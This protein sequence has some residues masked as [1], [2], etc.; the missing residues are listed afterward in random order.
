[1][2]RL[3]MS[4][5]KGEALPPGPLAGKVVLVAGAS[6]G[7]G[8]A[9]A[10]ASAEAGADVATT[11]R[12]NLAGAEAMAADVRATGRRAVVVPADI[13]REEDLARLAGILRAEFDRVDAW[14]NNAGADILTGAGAR[15]PRLEKL[16]LLLAVDLRGTMLASWAAADVMRTQPNGGTIINMSWDG[17]VHGLQGENPELFSAVKGG[18][19]SFSKSLARSVAPKIRVNVLCPGWIETAFGTGAHQDFKREVA[20]AIPLGRWGTPEDVAGAAVFLASDASSYLTGQMI[21]INGG[22][23]M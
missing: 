12:T 15:L 23:V 22:D 7:I 8:R 10:L 14:I 2:L 17:A 3:T 21:M 18:V 6:S 19:L 4:E 5:V 11:Y 20:A 1:M 9:M 13:A 16:D